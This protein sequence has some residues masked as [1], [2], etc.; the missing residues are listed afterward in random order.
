MYVFLRKSDTFLQE[1]ALDVR[2]PLEIQGTTT[3]SGGAFGRFGFD[4]DLRGG[5]APNAPNAYIYKAW[6]PRK[7]QMLIFA[8]FGRFVLFGLYKQLSFLRGQMPH[9]GLF[10]VHI[11]EPISIIP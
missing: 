8:V 3:W 9:F 10:L 6:A 11:D 5:D 4:F 2:F 1:S 7:R